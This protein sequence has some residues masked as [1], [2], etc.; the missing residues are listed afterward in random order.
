MK[1]FVLGLYI[2]TKVKVYNHE[3]PV[4]IFMSFLTTLKIHKLRTA[5]CRTNKNEVFIGSLEAV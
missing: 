2:F 5:L 1:L 3:Y 4:F